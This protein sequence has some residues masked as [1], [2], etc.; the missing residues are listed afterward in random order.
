MLGVAKF[1]CWCVWV[2]LA[3]S[4]SELFDHPIAK[5]TSFAADSFKSETDFPFESISNLQVYYRIYL[6]CLVLSTAT[7][8]SH[9][10]IHQ[11]LAA[12]QISNYP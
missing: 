10:L 2:S 5:S 7:H 3:P 9:M 1:V 6:H 8:P 12:Q 4:V 11:L